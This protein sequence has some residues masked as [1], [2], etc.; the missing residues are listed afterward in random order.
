M[1]LAVTLNEACGTAP[2]GS[3][4]RHPETTTVVEGVQ[5]ALHRAV[6]T[7]SLSTGIAHVRR[8]SSSGLGEYP[9]TMFGG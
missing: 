1:M 8:G 5:H 4:G 9:A 2:D 3:R 7:A 6:Y